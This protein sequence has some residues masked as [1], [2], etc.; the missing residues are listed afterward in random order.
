MTAS[1]ATAL[2]ATAIPVSPATTLPA[3]PAAVNRP[4][5]QDTARG[6]VR[7]VGPDPV[8]RLSLVSAAG[9]APLALTGEQQSALAAAEGL[10]VMVTGTLT[11]ERAMDAAP[12]G[13]AVFRVKQFVVR[14]ADG[15]EAHDGVLRETGGQFL[16]ET[17][18]TARTPIVDLPAAL[19]TQIG[20]RIFLVGPPNRSP[21]AYG[22]LRA[23]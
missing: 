5:Q 19:R 9:T 21:Q 8:S 14:A 22:V 23:K 3:P 7:R 12:G 4:A 17:S 18:P 10:E 20:A 1:P 11:T 13:A 2:P 6:I 16:L 15:V